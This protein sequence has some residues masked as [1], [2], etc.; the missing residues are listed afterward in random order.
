M[1][2]YRR[3]VNTV[4]QDY[5]LFPHMNVLDHT[6]RGAMVVTAPDVGNG[7]T[8]PRTMRDG[9]DRAPQGNKGPM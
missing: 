8:I 2:P 5:A 3:N 1:P 4:F 9:L 7:L 6:P